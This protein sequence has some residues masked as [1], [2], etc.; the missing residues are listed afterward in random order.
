MRARVH[1]GS[2][3]RVRPRTW[4]RVVDDLGRRGRG[5]REAGAFLLARPSAPSTVVSWIPYDDLDPT[6]LTGGISFSGEAFGR[7]SEHC[8]ST[9]LQVAADIHTHPGRAVRQSTI[10]RNNPMMTTKGHVALIVPNLGV[11]AASARDVGV[12]RYLG[13][14]TWETRL[15]AEAEVVLYIGW[16]A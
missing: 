2:W 8:R 16:L 12:H 14:R 9:G 5:E 4:R 7:L 1:L 11:R 13:G 3:L 10:D 6:C 15:G